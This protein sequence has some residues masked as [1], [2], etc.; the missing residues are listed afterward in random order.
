[1]DAYQ[2]LWKITTRAPGV[3]IFCPELGESFITFLSEVTSKRR[4]T[5]L[6]N[7]VN[8]GVRGLPTRESFPCV[9]WRRRRPHPLPLPPAS[10][11]P[12]ALP[13]PLVHPFHTFPPAPSPAAALV[14]PSNSS[15]PRDIRPL[16]PSPVTPPPHPVPC[17]LPCHTSPTPATSHPN[18]CHI[19]PLV[20]FLCHITVTPPP[21]ATPSLNTPVPHASPSTPLPHFSPCPSFCYTRFL[22]PPLLHPSPCPLPLLHF[23]PCHNSARDF[24]V[25]RHSPAGDAAAGHDGTPA[26][27]L[28]WVTRRV[29]Q[30]RRENLLNYAN[31]SFILFSVLFGR[32]SKTPPV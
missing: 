21:L 19:S 24:F 12:L 10:A 17:P 23:S 31:R 2:C 13:L 30:E 7:C 28:G 18:P 11:T 27:L 6:R 8:Q 29:A 1:M 22:A 20:P 15:F 32:S 14:L 5:G 25:C 9:S 26:G 16:V 3:R 4:R